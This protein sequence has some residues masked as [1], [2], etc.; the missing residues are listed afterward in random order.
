MKKYTFI[1]ISIFLLNFNLY[2]EEKKCIELKGAKTINKE[3]S[4]Y[5]KCIAGKMKPKLNTDSKLTDII[6]GKRKIKK[7]TFNTDSKL[8]DVITGKEKIK[9]PNPM[10]GLKNIGKALKPSAL[11]K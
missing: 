11:E 9:I 3:S 10:T 6:E 1:I 8:T 7:P 5:F 4:E 2:S